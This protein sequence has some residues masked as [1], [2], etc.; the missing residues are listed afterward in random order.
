MICRLDWETTPN[1]AIGK[2]G[3]ALEQQADRP[4]DGLTDPEQA[5]CQRIFLRLTQPGAAHRTFSL[6]KSKHYV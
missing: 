4:F 3:G 2:L 5:A 6:G 1:K